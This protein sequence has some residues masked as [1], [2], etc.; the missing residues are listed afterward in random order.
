MIGPRSA[1]LTVFFVG[2]FL[3]CI[4]VPGVLLV[5]FAALIVAV[6]VTYVVFAIAENQWWPFKW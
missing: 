5:T 6:V 2:Y 3:L 4:F 1:I